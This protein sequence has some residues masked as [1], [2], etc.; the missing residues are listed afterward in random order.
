MH[1]YE[2]R[3]SKDSAK[4]LNSLDAKLAVRIAKAIGK[5]ATDSTPPGCRKMIGSES[6]YRIR[7]GD[8]RVVYQI[9]SLVVMIFVIRIGHRKD[10]YR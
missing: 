3:F 9:R 1:P 2:I 5:L 8:Y 7:V 4:T 10:I 6:D